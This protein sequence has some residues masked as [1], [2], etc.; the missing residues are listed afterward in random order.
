MNNKYVA[1]SKALIKSVNKYLWPISYDTRPIWD[2]FLKENN[3]A[4]IL[5]AIRSLVRL[6][7][8]RFEPS[9]NFKFKQF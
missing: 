6:L 7:E 1:P 3:L 2:L 9:G 5:N 8:N 4:V